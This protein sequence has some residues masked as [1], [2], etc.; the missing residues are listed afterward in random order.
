MFSLL[1]T[2]SIPLTPI[3]GEIADQVGEGMAVAVSTSAREVPGGIFSSNLD[4]RKLLGLRDRGDLQ[5]VPTEEQVDVRNRRVTGKTI[6]ALLVLG[7][8]LG[9]NRRG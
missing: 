3:D 9:R 4:F 2:T 7:F 5:E 8:L 1:D 6:F